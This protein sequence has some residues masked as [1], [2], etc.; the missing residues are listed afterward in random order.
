MVFPSK[1]LSIVAKALEEAILLSISYY[2][3]ITASLLV[4]HLH[5][6]EGET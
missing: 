2:V 6:L 1:I 4:L 3:T 5:Q